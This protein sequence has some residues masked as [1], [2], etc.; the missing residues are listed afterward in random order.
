MSIPEGA[1]VPAASP[2]SQTETQTKTAELFP[3]SKVVEYLHA[4]RR[5]TMNV[6][7]EI[8]KDLVGHVYTATVEVQSIAGPFHDP[9]HHLQL[10]RHL[11]EGRPVALAQVSRP[12]VIWDANGD[13]QLVEVW[14]KLTETGSTFG[15][16]IDGRCTFHVTDSDLIKKAAKLPKGAKVSITAKLLFILWEMK[17]EDVMEFAEVQR[18][19]VLELPSNVIVPKDSDLRE[20]STVETTGKTKSRSLGIAEGSKFKAQFLGLTGSDVTLRKE[21]GREV[22]VPLDRLSEQDQAWVREQGK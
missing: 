11:T 20:W 21:N 10:I 15:D 9:K 19:E 3:I 22:T 16:S 17:V 18:L 5:N 7:A 4:H 8:E 6:N 13:V 2:S 14:T 12:K 1:R